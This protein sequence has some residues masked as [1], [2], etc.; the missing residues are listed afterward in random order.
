MFGNFPESADLKIAISQYSG[1]LE[2]WSGHEGPRAQVTVAPGAVGVRRRN[3][4]RRERTAERDLTRHV[5][6]VDQLAAFLGVEGKFPDKPVPR[7]EI[8]EW[9]RKSRANMTKALCEIDFSRMMSRG[10]TPAMV[11]LT[12]PGK[13]EMVVPTGAVAK[14]HLQELARRYDRAWGERPQGIW[15][16]EFQRR[17]AP[18]FHL[19]MCPPHGVALSRSDA[20]GAGLP[21]RDWLSVVWADI[22]SHPDPIEHLNHLKAGTGIDYAEGMR[23]SD[24]R[25]VSV[26]FTKHGQFAAKQYQHIVPELWQTPGAG[27]GRFWGYWQ[28][29]RMVWAVEVP[30]RDADV[31][32]RVLRRWSRA[33]LV[34]REVRAPRMAGGRIIPK[35]HDVIGLAGAQLLASRGR[36]KHR[37][38]R[39]RTERLRRGAG[40]VAVNDGASFAQQIAEYLRYRLRDGVGAVLDRL[41]GGGAVH[42]AAT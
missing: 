31:V 39:R 6:T 29:D 37:K 8:T 26:Y 32:A 19:L 28:L 23:A 34:L 42:A 10:R 1:R 16:L 40:W 3:L 36:L 22:V 35:Y 25:R 30:D 7:R 11:T 12:Y 14:A 33:Q 27:P 13:W 17:G 41:S 18:H 15:K 20:A 5:K 4:A 2:A 9:S 24:P 38:V 21:F